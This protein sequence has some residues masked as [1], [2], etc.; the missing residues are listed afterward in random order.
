MSVDDTHRPVHQ[1]IVHERFQQGEQRL[2]PLLQRF[3]HVLARQPE[4]TLEKRKGFV[5]LALIGRL[6]RSKKLKKQFTS[7]RMVSNCP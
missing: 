6:Q 2:A 1:R 4:C 5:I 3:Q 7:M